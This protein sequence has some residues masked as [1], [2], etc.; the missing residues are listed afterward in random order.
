MTPDELRAIM[1][2]LRGRVQ[3]KPQEGE[4]PAAIAFQAPTESEMAAAGLNAEGT[5]R[6]LSVPW[7]NEMVEDIVETPDMCDPGDPPQ[8]ILEY[9]QDV[10]SEYIRKR[11]PLDE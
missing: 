10:V 1:S 3:L 4:G 7:W 6:I 5:K 11:F 2:F 9:A 8:Q